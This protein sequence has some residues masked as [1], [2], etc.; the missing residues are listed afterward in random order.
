[1]TD[2]FS[3]EL[4]TPVVS[5]ARYS[6]LVGYTECAFFGV[7]H[8]DNIKYAC[9]EVW[10]AY[11]RQSVLD[12]LIE[13][14][15]E[16]ENITGYPLSNRW[17]SDEEH[18]FAYGFRFLA[19]FGKVNAIGAKKTDTLGLNVAVSHVTDPATVTIVTAITSKEDIHVFYP[20]TDIEIIPSVITLSG[21][22][23]VLSIPRCRMVAQA[24]LDDTDID[25][26]TVTNFQDT[27]DVFQYSTDVTKQG[28]IVK[29][30]SACSTDCTDSEEAVCVYIE[31]SEMGILRAGT[32]VEA[33]CSNV[34]ACGCDKYSGKTLKINY[35]AG[36]KKINR[37]IEMAIIRLAHSR[38]PAEP[39]GCDV[40][41]RLWLQDSTVPD[42]MDRE[43]LNC[44]FGTSDGAWQAYRLAISLSQFRMSEFVGSK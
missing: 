40:L 27:V 35:R 37:S 41:K 20:G 21:G 6:Q 12:A 38:M 4:N 42:I 28:T 11:Q 24:F 25:Y 15:E 44:P 3:F 16:I 29:L 10:T 26:F 18:R 32:S 9:R 8:P 5:L 19:G 23:L 43:R 39:C 34:S 36:M 31:N 14:Q 7:V 1:M 22:N 30:P 17:M 2:I 13:A 33:S